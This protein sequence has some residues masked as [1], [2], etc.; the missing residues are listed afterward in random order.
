MSAG[1]T[2]A[3]LV[4]VT[5]IPTPAAAAAAP[6]FPPAQTS[7]SVQVKLHPTQG[8]PTGQ[9]KLVT[10]GVP[11]PRGSLAPSALNTVRVLRGSTEIPAY[12]DQMTPWRHTT[13]A[14]LDGTSVRVARV[15]INLS[16]GV[17]YPNF[18][19]V[20][21]SWGGQQR[22]SNVTTLV[23][24]RTAWHRVTDGTTA[25]GGPTFGSANN[26]F[27]PDVYAVFPKT[28]LAAGGLKA[29]MDP[30][31]DS[32]GPNRIPANQVAASYPGYQESD[33]A[34]VNFFYTILNEDDPLTGPVVEGGNTN[35]FLTSDEPWLYDRA[36][37]MYIGYL[38]TGY[39]RFLRE[40]VRN[41]EFYRTQLWTPA[42]CNG[43]RC[44][45]S[46]KPKNP[47]ASAP[48]HDQK[49]SYNEPLAMTHWLTG[50]TRPLS[51]IEDVTKVYDDVNTQVNPSFYTERHIGLKLLANVVAYEVTGKAVYKDRM[52]VILNDFRQAQLHPLDG[53]P[54]DGGIW[55]SLVAHEG[56]PPNEEQTIT[57][58][59]MTALLADAASR[60]YLVSEHPE[61]RNLLIGLAS[62]ECGVGSYWSTIR[63]GDNPLAEHN[64]GA[65]VYLP[66]YLAT[67]D[68]LGVTDEF[69]PWANMEHTPDVA[70][71]VAWGAYFAGVN[72]DT[73]KQNSLK[74]CGNDLYT[75]WSHV[76]TSWTRP[77]APASNL[78]SYR[79]NPPRKYTWWFKNS[80]SFSWAM[81]SG[82]GDPAPTCGTSTTSAVYNRTFASSTRFDVVVDATPEAVADTGV[83]I[84]ANPPVNEANS[85]STATTVR[86]N[87]ANNRI[88]ARSAGTYPA[89]T[90]PWTAG[91]KYR[92]R[93]SVDVPAHTYSAFVTPPGGS[94]LTIGTG[95][96]F[97]SNYAS[98]TALNNLRGS[99]DGG[100]IQVCPVTLP[101]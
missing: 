57:S 38:R 30:M 16:F 85:F 74:Q 50:D 15:Q 92:I 4:T 3:V 60:L 101:A 56:V 32:I 10:F 88:E 78:D 35:P 81:G 27:E 65:P 2:I 9:P 95:L 20:T 36:E 25:T 80:G 12:V 79:V 13:N 8:V 77:N 18:E 70:G 31:V 98:V 1:T 55:H 100:S 23:D 59:W 14:A 83:G 84:G 47:D 86:F 91:Q 87:T 75:S 44:V 49:Y 19:T 33:Q 42:D 63:N 51:Q 64:G 72:G 17:S 73:A 53:G 29:P 82:S 6:F 96:A 99:V 61:V 39:L 45:G 26:V 40:A 21:V 68:G 48:W 5:G 90:I 66:H 22:G 52:L 89:T 71:V 58:P 37:V 28:W 7:G 94:E 34:Q 54:V 43:G 24:A 11:L 46:F 97:R 67:R 62:H 41:A 93:F 69:D 76:I